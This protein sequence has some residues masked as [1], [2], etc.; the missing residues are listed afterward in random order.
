MKKKINN[1]LEMKQLIELK[2]DH[3]YV[4]KYLACPEVDDDKL[5]LLW[6]LYHDLEVSEELRNRTILSTMLVQI[7]LDTHEKVTNSDETADKAEK[8]KNRQL[9]VLAGDYYS[10]LY[11]KVL[12]G[13]GDS[14]LIRLLSG[15]IK[16]INDNKIMLYQVALDDIP[17]ILQSLKRI[18]SS[19]I[20]HLALFYKKPDWQETAEDFL[21][22]KRLHAEKRHYIETGSSSF[23]SAI[24]R[25]FTAGQGT[26]KDFAGLRKMAEDRM[27]ECVELS[28]EALKKSM[29]GI[30]S[31]DSALY[32]RAA[33]L[34][35]QTEA[36]SNSYVREG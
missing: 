25:V 9:T 7:A 20:C 10:G 35:Q 28:R 11:Y 17:S 5:L 29:G 4:L 33:E 14:S 32:Q 12:A 2:A 26:E 27:D 23:Y 19:L 36:K 18:E 16:E 31:I 21:L 15:A 3:P 30:L 22:L 8:L 13:A 34:L 24:L 1:I 6:G